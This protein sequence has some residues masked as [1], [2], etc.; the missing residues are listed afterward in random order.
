MI[1]ELCNRF[2][3]QDRTV[4]L[5]PAANTVLFPSIRH[6]VKETGAWPSEMIFLSLS[7]LSFHENDTKEPSPNPIRR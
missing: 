6:G 5:F 3:S 7:C 4:A 1:G 2:F